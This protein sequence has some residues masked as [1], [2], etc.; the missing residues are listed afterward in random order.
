MVDRHMK[1]TTISRMRQEINLHLFHHHIRV[2]FAGWIYSFSLAYAF[3]VY[4]DLLKS[5]SFKAC[6]DKGAFY[7]YNWERR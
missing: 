1:A 4:K 7:F 5:S 6:Q 3:R 2:R